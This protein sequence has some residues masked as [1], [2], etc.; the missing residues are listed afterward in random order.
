M[1]IQRLITS[2]HS[3]GVAAKLHPDAIA[4]ADLT[5]P[6]GLPAAISWFSVFAVFRSVRRATKNLHPNAISELQK[7]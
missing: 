4:A 1:I 5:D 6:E 7:R 2:A 3:W